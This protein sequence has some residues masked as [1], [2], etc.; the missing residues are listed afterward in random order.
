MAPAGNIVTLAEY[1][2][3]KGLT[4]PQAIQKAN[5]RRLVIL[6]N[7]FLDK[8]LVKTK[9]RMPVFGEVWSGTAVAYEKPGKKLGKEIVYA[10]PQTKKRYVFPVKPDFRGERGLL[11]VEHDF[12]GGKPTFEI[13]Q[14]GND[15]VFAVSKEAGVTRVTG[16]P[17]KDGEYYPNKFGIPIGK[18]VDDFRRGRYLYRIDDGSF[19]GLLTRRCSSSSKRQV[20]ARERPSE[21][22]GVLAVEIPI[23]AA[24]KTAADEFSAFFSGV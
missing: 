4:A 12:V 20:S 18:Q 17:S 15:F 9:G 10:D 23:V 13:L 5:E 16:F 6:S 8:Q 22:C 2:G 3:N 11:V 19:A 21:R 1:C 14:D 24:G 7:K